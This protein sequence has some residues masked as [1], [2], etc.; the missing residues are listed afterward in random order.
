MTMDVRRP[1][2]SNHVVWG[3]VG[4]GVAVG[5][6][7]GCR[8]GRGTGRVDMR[9]VAVVGHSVVVSPLVREIE[10]SKRV[11]RA[12]QVVVVVAIATAA[13]RK[14]MG[15]VVGGVVVGS[16]SDGGGVWLGVVRTGVVYRRLI[17]TRRMSNSNTHTDADADA[18]T[19]TCVAGSIAISADDACGCSTVRG[20]AGVAEE[21]ALAIAGVVDVLVAGLW[22]CLHC[23]DW[24]LV[25]GVVTEK[26]SGNYCERKV[27]R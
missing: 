16:S 23:D 2:L 20:L 7:E 3:L 25:T 27:A 6:V 9:R 14:R 4:L 22:V 10:V 19:D 21:A 24:R 18:D 1:R 26:R 13:I 5:N 11:H 12:I 15:I 8:C 17:G